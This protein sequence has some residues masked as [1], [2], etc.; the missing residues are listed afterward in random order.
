MSD[1]AILGDAV[2]EPR[3]EDPTRLLLRIENKLLHQT[4]ARTLLPVE[5]LQIA[6]DLDSEADLDAAEHHRPDIALVGCTVPSNYLIANIARIRLASP[7]TRI[8]A[9][10]PQ[11]TAELTSTLRAVGVTEL[12]DLD[13]TLED[14][15]GCLRRTR[16]APSPGRL[17]AAQVQAI[18]ARLQCGHKLSAREREIVDLVAQAMSNRQIASKLRITEGTVK[19]HMRNIFAKLRANS[20]IDAVNKATTTICCHLPVSS[21]SHGKVSVKSTCLGPLCDYFDSAQRPPL[22]A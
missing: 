7:G 19:R 17:D 13:S 3:F 21:G 15:L 12:T 9:L 14:L 10:V 5:N 11:V 18:R 8:I 22:S 4:V 1:G 6:E 16:R 2:G 20:R